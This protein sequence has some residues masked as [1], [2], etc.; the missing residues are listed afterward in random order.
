ML[1]IHSSRFISPPPDNTS[2][3]TMAR[4]FAADDDFEVAAGDYSNKNFPRLTAF[5]KLCRDF[6]IFLKLKVNS[7]EQLAYDKVKG[8]QT[9]ASEI[10]EKTRNA[11]PDL[12]EIKLDSMAFV[13]KE[14]YGK[15]YVYISDGYS[16][17]KIRQ[18]MTIALIVNKSK[19]IR[20]EP[21]SLD[22]IIENS[23]DVASRNF[24]S[25][26]DHKLTAEYKNVKL[27][28]PWKYW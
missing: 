15:T 12:K 26:P 28:D 7:S 13:E 10:V 21:I 17:I 23:K 18:P 1:P 8:L 6:L 4:A 25:I 24:F 9:I 2:I 16:E 19:K 5:I 27:Q 22:K 20:P 11:D 3:K 14:E